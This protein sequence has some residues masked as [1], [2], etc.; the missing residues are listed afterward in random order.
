MQA[1][2]AGLWKCIVQDS[3]SN[4]L[5]NICLTPRSYCSYIIKS[6]LQDTGGAELYKLV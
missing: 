3:K 2:S 6:A 5:S 4:N 1:Y